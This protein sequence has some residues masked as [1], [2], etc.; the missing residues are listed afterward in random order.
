[1]RQNATTNY[2]IKVKPKDFEG[3]A[4]CPDFSFFAERNREKEF[5]QKAQQK[6]GEKGKI[7]RKKGIFLLDKVRAI[8]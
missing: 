4:D 2:W 1:M 8:W 3:G 7:W 6:S 5:G